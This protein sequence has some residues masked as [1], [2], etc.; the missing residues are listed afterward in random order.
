MLDW[1][2]HNWGGAVGVLGLLFTVGGFWLAIWQIRLSK[3]AAEQA[4]AAARDA[5]VASR[6]TREEIQKNIGIAELETI[7]RLIDDVKRFHINR[8]WELAREK[9][10]DI[11][12]GL[13]RLRSFHPDMDDEDQVKISAAI[14]AIDDLDRAIS[15]AL[16]AKK[17][18]STPLKYHG[19]LS[20]VQSTLDVIQ[21]RLQFGSN[22]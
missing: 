15:G 9:Y 16:L 18:P 12:R 7:G 2:S 6:E 20:E 22:A 11:R 5:A 1:L 19:A 10:N 3:R 21:R 8:K 13:S 17:E 14:V 4:A